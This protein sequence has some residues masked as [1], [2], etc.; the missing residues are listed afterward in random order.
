MSQVNKPEALYSAALGTEL[1]M[2][3]AEMRKYVTKTGGRY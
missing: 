1:D 2:E 3:S